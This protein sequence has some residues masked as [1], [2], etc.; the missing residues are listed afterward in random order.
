MSLLYWGQYLSVNI[1][2]FDNQ[3]KNIIQYINE[4]RDLYHEKN[5]A[6]SLQEL[7][8]KLTAYVHEH[9]ALEEEYFE[10]YN[11][12][13]AEEHVQEHRLFAKTMNH[14]QD[15]IHANRDQKET[16]LELL[17]FLSDWLMS[18]IQQTDKAYT[19]F[20]NKKGIH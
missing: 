8:T 15:N 10:K 12:P 6:P 3:H 11:Y 13:H 4:L 14:F 17:G 16:I 1:E 2:I 19:D 7:L 20:F 5:E 9:L 18:H